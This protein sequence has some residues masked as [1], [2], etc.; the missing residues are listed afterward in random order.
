MIPNACA[1]ARTNRPGRLQFS[2]VET[3]VDPVTPELHAVGLGGGSCIE[4]ERAGPMLLYK[5]Y[6]ASYD[7][8]GAY[9]V[10]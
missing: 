8:T 9:T 6:T 2:A 4:S 3:G 7:D 5:L 10:Q 1:P